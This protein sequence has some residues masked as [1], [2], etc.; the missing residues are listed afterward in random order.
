MKYFKK[1]I[2]AIKI[3]LAGEI[4]RMICILFAG[5]AGRVLN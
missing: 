2:G 5:D 4:I 3:E 1:L